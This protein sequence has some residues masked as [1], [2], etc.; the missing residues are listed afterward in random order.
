MLIT[1]DWPLPRVF[2]PQAAKQRLKTFL[3]SIAIC[4]FV[5]ARL[6]SMP[7]VYLEYF[8]RSSSKRH[9]VFTICKTENYLHMLWQWRLLIVPLNFIINQSKFGSANF[10]GRIVSL[11]SHMSRY[12]F[13]WH[14][15][16]MPCVV[17]NRGKKSFNEIYAIQWC[18]AN[19]NKACS[20]WNDFWV[21]Y[22]W[23]SMYNVVYLNSVCINILQKTETCACFNV[24]A[25][26][27]MSVRQKFSESCLW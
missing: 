1:D 9:I 23:S 17:M 18:S 14:L 26:G 13:I 25:C 4:W 21:C 27:K 5:C 11:A 22:Y 10:R 16:S 6:Q 12:K 20:V 15:H 3:S 8:R 2:C 19:L 24:F 7:S